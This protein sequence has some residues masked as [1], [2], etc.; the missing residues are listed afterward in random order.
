M[1]LKTLLIVVLSIIATLSLVACG[2]G[3]N[4]Q[5]SAGG[6]S[7]T[8]EE[9]K[10]DISWYDDAGTLIQ[11]TSVKEG[12]APTLSWEKNDT[13]EF[14]YTL[15][16][17]A[18]TLGGS[19]LSTLP[20]AS[21]N[22]S[23]YAVVESKKQVYTVTFNTNGGSAIE[24]VKKEYN[25]ELTEPEKPTQSGKRF[26]GWCTDKDLKVAVQWPLKVT[27]NVTL[28]ALWN[29]KVDVVAYLEQL[30]NG[31]KL[32][33]YSYIPTSM[34][35]GNNL[36]TD[37]QA[38]IDYSNFV[39]KGDLLDGGFGEQWNMVSDNL[40]QSQMFFKVLSVVENLTTT[41]V[42]TFNNWFDKNPSD[43]AHHNFKEGI[44]S[45]TIDFDGKIIYYVLD[46]TATV[47]GSEQS[48]QIALSMDIETSEK[49]VRLQ[50]GDANALF[51][52]VRENSYEFA[53][54]Y[55]G[56]RRAYFSVEKDNSGKVTGHI[57][58]I[59]TAANIST[60]S[61]ADF[62]ITSDYVSA[63][64][65]KAS[66]IPG[67]KGYISELY[68]VKTG[69]ML[70]YEVR[71]TLTVASNDITYNTLWFKL[72]DVSGINSIKYQE[73]TDTTEAAF[74]VNGLTTPWEA[75]KV[76]GLSLKTASRRYDIEFR[77][78]YYYTYNQAEDKYTEVKVKVPMLFV[79]E[80]NYSTLNE[81]I[82][83]KNTGVNANVTMNTADLNK[84]KADYASLVDAFIANKDFMTEEKIL[85]FIGTKV[86]FEK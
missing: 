64:G 9:T 8:V 73:K 30:L 38:N 52:K 37:A 60:T 1:K 17:W 4:Q 12:T 22:A 11:T 29:D 20:N 66:G 84:L 3:N 47:F 50:I 67:F 75:K 62:Y 72:S 36:I 54:R 80:E 16:G 13:V 76:G 74:Y 15:K 14:D 53:I 83:D 68:N 57:Y 5:N 85:N 78:Q 2:G 10:Y 33:P 48:V 27:G 23:Y 59:L 21:A 43:T 58:E 6:N 7:S 55:L 40:N 49:N 82:A 26:M 70:G 24:A 61:A 56:V 31:Y 18:T 79:Q 39:N 19:A 25:T 28:Y 41:S 77:T 44:Y 65:N 71:E 46:Y 45:V 51:Y 81:D 34:R 63:V 35:P 32:D 69:K 42:A 86:T